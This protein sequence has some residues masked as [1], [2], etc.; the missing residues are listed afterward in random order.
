MAIINF[1]TSMNFSK[2]CKAMF[3]DK[4]NRNL[5]NT[6]FSH[7]LIN[8]IVKH[9]TVHI[10]DETSVERDLRVLVDNCLLWLLLT[11]SSVH[12]TASSFCTVLTFGRT[13]YT[14]Q[15]H[16]CRSRKR[17]SMPSRLFK[18]AQPSLF[19]LCDQNQQMNVV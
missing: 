15:Q 4:S 17:T 3:F 12:S 2:K 5:H 18:T 16:A 6:P 7:I 9:G 19:P 11:Y 1:S 8:M 14:A 10:L 13:W